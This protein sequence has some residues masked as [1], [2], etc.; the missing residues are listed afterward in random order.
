MN[1]NGGVSYPYI[2]TTL[3]D[4]KSKLTADNANQKGKIHE[5]IVVN[6]SP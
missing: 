6:Q 5:V 3:N 2:V 4:L 1:F